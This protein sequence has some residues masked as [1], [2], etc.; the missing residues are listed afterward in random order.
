[1]NNEL[2]VIAA[3]FLVTSLIWIGD[4]FFRHVPR[5]AHWLNIIW[6]APYA[7]IASSTLVPRLWISFTRMEFIKLFMA[8]VAYFI[9]IFICDF[10]LFI[11]R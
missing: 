9:A 6:V 11:Q 5:G 2:R 7:F 3:L 8:S 4:F 10:L 1:M